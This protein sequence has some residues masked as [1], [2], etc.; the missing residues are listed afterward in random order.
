MVI[1]SALRQLGLDSVLNFNFAAA[2][3]KARGTLKWSLNWINLGLQYIAHSEA[4]GPSISFASAPPDRETSAS[5]YSETLTLDS[6]IQAQNIVPCA[7]DSNGFPS[8]YPVAFQFKFA[9]VA[10]GSSLNHDFSSWGCRRRVHRHANLIRSRRI[11]LKF[12]GRLQCRVLLNA[13]RHTYHAFKTTLQAAQFKFKCKPELLHPSKFLKLSST[14]VSFKVEPYWKL[15]GWL[16]AAFTS[17]LTNGFNL[18]LQST[19]WIDGLLKEGTIAVQSGSMFLR[20]SPLESSSSSINE[21][22]CIPCGAKLLSAPDWLK[23]IMANNLEENAAPI[24]IDFKMVQLRCIPSR[25]HS[26]SHGLAL[27]MSDFRFNQVYT[28][29]SIPRS[30]CHSMGRLLYMLPIHFN[31][32]TF[33]SR[34]LVRFIQ[35]ISYP[36]QHVHTPLNMSIKSPALQVLVLV[37]PMYRRGSTFNIA[38]IVISISRL[39]LANMLR[40]RGMVRFFPHRVQPK[41]NSTNQPFSGP[42][43]LLAQQPIRP[44]PQVFQLS[45]EP[46]APP[47]P[48]DI[49]GLHSIL[50]VEFVPTNDLLGLAWNNYQ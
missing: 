17:A 11:Q 7:E 13:S 42:A 24:W 41:A 29:A 3:I 1:C 25:F 48:F 12:E 16:H 36:A 27:Q 21:S 32:F 2:A 23:S 50:P 5:L 35:D 8:Y 20:P 49:R 38:S 45:F 6:R 26:G 37:F 44:Q 43:S 47:F 15:E 9:A 19:Q 10:F 22:L 31:A 28:F 4:P 39:Q 30:I 34:L 18:G 14:A 33:T 40:V 46:Q